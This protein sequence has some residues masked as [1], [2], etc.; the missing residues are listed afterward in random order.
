MDQGKSR[1]SGL[2]RTGSSLPTVPSVGRLLSRWTSL[3]RWLSWT[4]GE[5]SHALKSGPTSASSRRCCRPDCGVLDKRR[6]PSEVVAGGAY[7][8]RSGSPLP[9]EL[10]RRLPHRVREANIQQ[11]SPYPTD[12]PNAMSTDCC[13]GSVKT[14]DC[15]CLGSVESL[16]LPPQASD[17]RQVPASTESE[18]QSGRSPASKKTPMTHQEPNCAGMHALLWSSRG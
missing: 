7:F 4:G 8:L 11:P 1:F 12:L 3:L 16:A 15:C 13:P 17:H 18:H 6:Q 9:H 5:E 10:P 2:G 14:T